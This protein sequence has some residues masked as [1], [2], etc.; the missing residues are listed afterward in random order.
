MRN[1]PYPNLQEH[2]EHSAYFQMENRPESALKLL[3]QSVVYNQRELKTGTEDWG[4]IY[5]K[6]VKKHL[7]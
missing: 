4:A 1:P 7:E 3:A 6:S 5:D 2:D